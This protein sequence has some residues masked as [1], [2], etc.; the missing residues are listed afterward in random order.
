MFKISRSSDKSS[1][2]VFKIKFTKHFAKP[3]IVKLVKFGDE[4][5]NAK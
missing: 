4:K 1:F 5:I 3:L 2:K